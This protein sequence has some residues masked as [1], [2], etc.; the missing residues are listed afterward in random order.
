MARIFYSMSGEGR[1]HATRVR[2]MTERLRHEHDLLLLAPGN[3]Y[4]LLAPC[5][6]RDPRVRVR[7]IPG[8]RFHYTRGRLDL[9]RSIAA[10]VSYLRRLESIVREIVE[11]IDRERPDLAVTDFEPALPRAAA[12]TQLPLVCLDHQHFLTECD[13]ST[14]D[15]PLRLS[16]L[17]MRPVVYAHCWGQVAT[18]VSS[19]YLPP[20]RRG[21]QHVT[22]VGP[23]LRPELAAARSQRGGYLLSYLRPNT[24]A[25]VVELLAATGRPTR[26][27][28][29]GERAPHGCLEFRPID[30]R[31][32]VTDLAGCEALIGAA[33]NQ[34]LGEALHLGKP[35]FALPERR[36]HEQRINSHFLRQMGGGDYRLLETVTATDLS[37]FL[38]QLDDYHRQLAGVCGR[39]DGTTAAET[40]IRRRLPG[41]LPALPLPD[42]ARTA[43]PNL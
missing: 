31:Q 12:R 37:A 15:W 13:L 36:H 39:L 28:G 8:L 40:V 23:L 5:Y 32:F 7:A 27:Y 10:G 19:F 20:L 18:V 43:A 41:G 6:R 38:E 2:A 22:R 34:T 29:L 11:L 21:R 3:A 16:T 24:P 30:E 9:I 1:G 4:E 14:L 17:S 33:G 35:V 26:V 25:R 42:P